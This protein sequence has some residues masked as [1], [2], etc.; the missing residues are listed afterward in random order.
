MNTDNFDGMSSDND[1]APPISPFNAISAF[2]SN[3]PAPDLSPAASD[4]DTLEAE[5]ALSL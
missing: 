4:L 5:S 3:S 2:S 1:E